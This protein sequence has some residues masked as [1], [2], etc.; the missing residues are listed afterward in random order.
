MPPP[1]DLFI[2]GQMELQPLTRTQGVSL[3]ASTG[4]L[5]NFNA[6]EFI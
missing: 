1:P 3:Y 5:Q 6:L 4:E 2:H